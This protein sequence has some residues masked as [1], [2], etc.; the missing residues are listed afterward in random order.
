MCMEMN[1]DSVQHIFSPQNVSVRSVYAYYLT[2][3][4][5]RGSKIYPYM[6]NHWNWMLEKNDLPNNKGKILKQEYC[7]I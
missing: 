7:L 3:T 5:N 4:L 2:S 6:S 1:V